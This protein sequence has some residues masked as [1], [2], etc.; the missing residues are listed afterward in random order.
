MFTVVFNF[1]SRKGYNKGAFVNMAL[2]DFF[3]VFSKNED[4]KIIKKKLAALEKS[5][6]EIKK[7]LA[8]MQEKNF[9]KMLTTRKIHRL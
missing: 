1:I 9:K 5:M 4:G 8:E 3:L 6:E 2:K 7:S